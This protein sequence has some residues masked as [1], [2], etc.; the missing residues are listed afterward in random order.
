MLRPLTLLSLHYFTCTSKLTAV[1]LV[2]ALSNYRRILPPYL[3]SYLSSRR[4]ASSSK[5]DLAAAPVGHAAAVAR[6]LAPVHP[7]RALALAAAGEIVALL[8]VPP[9]V[10]RGVVDEPRRAECLGRLNVPR[11]RQLLEGGL[12]LA[13]ALGL[14]SALGLLG[15][16][17]AL[18]AV[19]LLVLLLVLFLGVEETPVGGAV[20]TFVDGE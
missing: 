2:L 13:L 15:T 5:V 12:A 4:A 14:G 9:V 8:G 6:V 7:R 19:G 1:L 16:R 20:V 17:A 3:L 10:V 18:G 11:V